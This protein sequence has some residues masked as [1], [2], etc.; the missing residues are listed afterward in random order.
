MATE[1]QL[2][3]REQYEK[4]LAEKNKA[5]KYII[6]MYQPEHNEDAKKL[7]QKYFTFFIEIKDNKYKFTT[8]F[9][10]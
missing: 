5:L 4:L 7:T 1:K 10:D 8:L 3:P 6:N 2:T 9:F